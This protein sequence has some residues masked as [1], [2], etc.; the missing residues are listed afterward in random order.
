LREADGFHRSLGSRGDRGSRVCELGRCERQL[1]SDCVR[2][3]VAKG[4]GAPGLR[5]FELQRAL[6]DLVEWV[7]RLAAD[8]FRALFEPPDIRHQLRQPAV[9]IR[10]TLGELL[11]KPERARLVL[12]V[13]A[14]EPLA[15]LAKPVTEARV[16]LAPLR[17][18]IKAK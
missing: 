18:S 16:E 5:L 11:R 3:L 1:C 14:L 12:L 6:R 17:P 2:D 8:R 4:A 7:V 15:P 13:Q 9:E 10:V